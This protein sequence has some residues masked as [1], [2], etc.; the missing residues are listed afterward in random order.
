MG[1]TRTD[2]KLD[3]LVAL[4]A[5]A[6]SDALTLGRHGDLSTVTSG[7]VLRTEGHHEP[8]SYCVLAGT[9]LL[10]A[11]NEAVAVAGAGAWLLGHVPGSAAAASPLS[12]VAGTDVE[13]LCFRPRD[14]GEAMSELP[15]LLRSGCS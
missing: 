6:T 1:P 11:G 2:G 9:V 7:A 15:G 12:I 13:L 5:C 4:G 10:S 8:W 14:L 3:R